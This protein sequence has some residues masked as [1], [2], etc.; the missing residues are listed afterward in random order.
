MKIQFEHNEHNGFF[1]KPVTHLG[2]AFKKHKSFMKM[3]YSSS[4]VN[5]GT[6]PTLSRRPTQTDA[7]IYSNGLN[8]LI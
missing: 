8:K 7:L 3:N 1:E 2:E 5:L 6:N 4:I